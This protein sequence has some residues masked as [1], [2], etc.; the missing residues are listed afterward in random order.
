MFLYQISAKNVEK[1]IQNMSS[2]QIHDNCRKIAEESEDKSLKTLQIDLSSIRNIDGNSDGNS[3]VPMR[4]ESNAKIDVQT[5]LESDPK[6]D[7]QMNGELTLTPKMTT[8]IERVVQ[9]NGE[10][11]SGIDGDS[12]FGLDSVTKMADKCQTKYVRKTTTDIL[13]KMWSSIECIEWHKS[14]EELNKTL[15]KRMFDLFNVKFNDNRIKQIMDFAIEDKL[16][17]IEESDRQI[18]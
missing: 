7:N 8:V 9:T 17:F 18:R 4:V 1:V 13:K 6:S 3:D 15:I 5:G 11:S 2:N 14:V 16:V 12:T 10:N